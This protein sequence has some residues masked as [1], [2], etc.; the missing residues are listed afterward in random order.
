MLDYAV[1]GL[2]L[3]AMATLIVY[4]RQPWFTDF[5]SVVLGVF[6]V[7]CVAI[8]TYKVHFIVSRIHFLAAALA[9][10]PEA[11]LRESGQYVRDLVHFMRSMNLSLLACLWTAGLAAD[12]R[13]RANSARGSTETPGASG[14]GAPGTT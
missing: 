4:R 1:A 2:A 12:L 14:V 13:S 10:N 8:L 11:P 3:V 6:I 7:I 5:S 9:E